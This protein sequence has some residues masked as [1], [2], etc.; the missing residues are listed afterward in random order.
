MRPL[1][2]AAAASLTVHGR[3]TLTAGVIPAEAG[4]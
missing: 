3:K 1:C 2:S 4:T